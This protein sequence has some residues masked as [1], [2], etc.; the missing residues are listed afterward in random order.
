MKG[1]DMRAAEP[2]RN[3]GQADMKGEETKTKRMD[4]AGK[5]TEKKKEIGQ[6]EM[7]K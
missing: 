5:P 1:H 2:D 3:C 4:S 7:G 6:N